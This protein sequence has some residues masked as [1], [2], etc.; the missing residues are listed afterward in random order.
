MKLSKKTKESLKKIKEKVKLFGQGMNIVTD[1]IVVLCLFIITIVGITSVPECK[2]YKACAIFL[3]AMV[4][5]KYGIKY[6]F[7]L[8]NHYSIVSKKSIKNKENK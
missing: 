5:L 4:S 8:A 7:Y 1:G 6:V 2:G 3:T